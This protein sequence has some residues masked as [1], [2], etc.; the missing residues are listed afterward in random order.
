VRNPPAARDGLDAA[1]VF[2][3]ARATPAVF[4]LAA[5]LYRAAFRVLLGEA[6]ERFACDCFEQMRASVFEIGGDPREVTSRTRGRFVELGLP[7]A[8][9]AY[10]SASVARAIQVAGLGDFKGRLLDIGAGDNGI[11]AALTARG[12]GEVA[13]VG[14]D[15]GP[16]EAARTG[17]GLDYVRVSDVGVLPFE[18]DV[19]DAALLRFSLHHMVP[20]VQR[21]TLIEALRVIR[22]EGELTVVEDAYAT[23][24]SPR[25]DNA[26]HGEF[27]ALSE[28]DERLLLLAFLD[29]SSLFISEDT[30][31][32]AFSYRTLEEWVLLLGEL[33]AP[34]CTTDYW[35]LP[36]ISIFQAPLSVLK[37]R[38]SD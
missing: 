30:M 36:L 24:V 7:S 3:A 15:L 12:D 31:P 21:R 9:G 22:P 33:G 1:L 6:A 11:G 38:A 18:D 10:R 8:V 20:D 28:P 35:G 2:E 5:E 23:T 4:D 34:A 19:F 26:L 37:A 27:L 25:F 13:V 14:C 16:T 17:N 29:A 32:F